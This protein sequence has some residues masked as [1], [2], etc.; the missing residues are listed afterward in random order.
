MRRTGWPARA[1]PGPGEAHTVR[2]FC[3]L[4]QMEQRKSDTLL[5]SAPGG[6]GL[7]GKQAGDYVFTDC[8]AGRGADAARDHDEARLR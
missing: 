6:C 1:N 2:D 5:A 7:S 3:G 4:R 8:E